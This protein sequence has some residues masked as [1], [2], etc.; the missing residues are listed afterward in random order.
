MGA[1]GG[2][3]NGTQVGADEAVVVILMMMM[4]MMMM[5]VMMMMTLIMMTM[6]LKITTMMIKTYI[7]FAFFDFHH[8]VI[9]AVILLEVTR[10]QAVMHVTNQAENEQ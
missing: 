5:M 8:N 2:D 3:N 6:M 4:M 7:C 1:H 10:M 9:N